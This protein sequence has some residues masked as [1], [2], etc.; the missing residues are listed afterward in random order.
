MPIDVTEDY[1]R[2]RVMQPGEFKDGS[3]RTIMLSK[4]KGIRSVVGRLK[5]NDKMRNQNFMFD[6]GKGWTETTARE[7]VEKRGHEIV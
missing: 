6:K 2:V 7:W 4:I 3:F 1:I 5:S